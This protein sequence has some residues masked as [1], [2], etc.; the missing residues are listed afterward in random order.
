[1]SDPRDEVFDSAGGLKFEASIAVDASVEY[2]RML[3][4]QRLATAVSARRDRALGFPES[5]LRHR[6]GD[7][8][9]RI[10]SSL[11]LA[12]GTRA[13][14]ASNSRRSADP[15]SQPATPWPSRLRRLTA[16][17]QFAFD[18]SDLTLLHGRQIAGVARAIVTSRRTTRPIR[19][20]VLV[21]HTDSAGRP[22]DNV[23]LGLRRAAAVARALRLAV[24]RLSPVVAR[25]LR[26][27]TRSAVSSGQ[28]LS[29]YRR[30]S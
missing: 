13:G 2:L 30:A 18:R 14:P 24:A 10:S 8:S 7:S 6:L 21:G 22:S 25:S 29:H 28:E 26:I 5:A 9:G 3:I 16:L 12:S 11:R 20:V 4:A 27:V 15:A 17:E 1:M 19:S 23:G